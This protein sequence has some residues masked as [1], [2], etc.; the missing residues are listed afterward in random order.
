MARK[1][2]AR[3]TVAEI[4]T[5]REML[6]EGASKPLIAATLG[7]ATSTVQYHLGRT[8]PSI[9]HSKLGP[10]REVIW[11]AFLAGTSKGALARKYNVTRPAIQ[12][13]L[14]KMRREKEQV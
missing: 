6:A 12:A 5:M 9:Y 3:L 10:H 7:C 2:Y 8:G 13:L 11:T 1:K 14:K 4:A